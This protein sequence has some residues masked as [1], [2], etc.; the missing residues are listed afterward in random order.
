MGAGSIRAVPAIPAREH[1]QPSY[2]T[3]K[4]AI[5]NRRVGGCLRRPATPYDL[6]G[7]WAPILGEVQRLPLTPYVRTR[8]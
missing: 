7:D 6:S 3:E 2:A 4:H 5:G 8:R 1:G